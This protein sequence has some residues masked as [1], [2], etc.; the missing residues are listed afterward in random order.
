MLTLQESDIAFSN[1]SS[2][3]LERYQFSSEPVNRVIRE[4]DDIWRTIDKSDHELCSIS[5]E[6]WKIKQTI[7]MWLDNFLGLESHVERLKTSVFPLMVRMPALAKSAAELD[8]LLREL[9]ECPVNPKLDFINGSDIELELDAILIRLFNPKLVC[10]SHDQGG[11]SKLF[12]SRDLAVIRSAREITRN[13]KSMIIP[14]GSVIDKPGIIRQAIF[15]GA[16]PRF[17]ILLYECED[18]KIPKRLRL[19]RSI[20]PKTTD[21][22]ES[23]T[24]I[25]SRSEVAHEEE[26]ANEFFWSNIHGA[27]RTKTNA[28]FVESYYL[29]FQNGTGTCLSSEGKVFCLGSSLEGFAEPSI[30]QTRTKDLRE[31]DWIVIKEGESDQLLDDVYGSMLESG[32]AG[33]SEFSPEW[34]NWLESVSLEKTSGQ[35]A[36]ELLA[37]GAKLTSAQITAWIEQKSYGP[38]KKS[39]FSVLL[40]YLYES[41]PNNEKG[42]VDVDSFI[43]VQWESLEAYRS[44][45]RKAGVLIREKLFESLRLSLEDMELD[46]NS[47][48]S[49]SLTSTS[50]AHLLVLRIAQIDD[51]AIFVPPGRIAKLDDHH[52]GGS[53]WL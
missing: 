41:R 25:P 16:A 8:R 46:P 7:L 9:I 34:V 35:I 53:R 1:C 12:G 19:K 37:R 15:S 38:S 26:W 5:Y 13:Y 28:E 31:G 24:V 10:W 51:H 27:A 40:R 4:I 52:R 36:K 44:T 6:L 43:S 32:D 22:E 21:I 42:D 49:V 45:R 3:K 50:Q 2:M 11:S 39:V 23:D 20:F 33:E 14:A 17:F 18:F 29:L 30:V 47:E 48:N